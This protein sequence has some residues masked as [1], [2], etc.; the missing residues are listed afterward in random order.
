MAVFSSMP[1]IGGVCFDG[2]DEKL[3]DTFEFFV[4]ELAERKKKFAGMGI[5]SFKEYVQ[6]NSDCPA[7]LLVLDNFTAFYENYDRFDDDLAVITREGS[8]YGIYTV[9]TS[10]TS[11]DLRSRLR[12]NFNTG[13]ALQMPDRFEYEAVIGEHTDIIPEGKTPGRGLIKAP[14]A[15]EFQVALPVK[16]KDGLSQAQ[17]I[18]KSLTSVKVD[19]GTKSAKKLGQ[20]LESLSIKELLEEAK[21]LPE[22]KF[23]IGKTMDGETTITFDM[24]NEYCISIVGLGKTG[25]TN[26]LKAIALTAKAKGDDIILFDGKSEELKDFAKTSK[27]K[28]YITDAEGLFKT[29][30]DEIVGKFGER[31]AI[32]NEAKESGKNVA[33][34][35]KDQKRIVILINDYTSFIETVYSEDYDMSNFFETAL[36]KGRDHKIH[37]IAAMTND[38]VSDCGRYQVSRQFTSMESG[39]CLG[40]MFDQQNVLHWEMSSADAVRQLPAGFGY[41]LTEDG[42]PVRMLTPLV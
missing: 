11:G 19:S 27:I 22:N 15:V 1:H 5:G 30:Q 18:K 9:I 14:S 41:A 16:E 7:L 42:A 39:V 8:S 38:D 25:K 29:M 34:A 23:A 32:V 33:E 31:N 10:N 17:S 26:L 4:N 2:E 12:Q 40:G 36:E 28:N 35:L 20:V 37:F 13:I 24:D 6:F 3:N 21:S